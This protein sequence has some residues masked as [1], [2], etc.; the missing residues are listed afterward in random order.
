MLSPRSKPRGACACA[1]HPEVPGLGHQQLSTSAEGVE[2]GATVGRRRP[3]VVCRPQG[4][5][6]LSHDVLRARRAPAM[7]NGR[8]TCFPSPGISRRGGRVTLWA[9]A[10]A[11][12]AAI[13]HHNPTTS[14]LTTTDRQLTATMGFPLLRTPGR[15][16]AA[17]PRSF[18]LPK[19][20][21][22]LRRCKQ[23]RIHNRSYL[24]GREANLLPQ[25]YVRPS[26][27]LV[28]QLGKGLGGGCDA[29]ASALS[30][31]GDWCAP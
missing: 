6:G 2:E 3:C 8:Q 23:C 16:F 17:W 30:A 10:S 15:L 22:P 5:N 27:R 28:Q 13:S 26:E 29:R 4:F 19:P 18:P 11:G 1:F 25:P 20:G 21:P 24:R 7:G 9:G 12:R 31:S 14:G